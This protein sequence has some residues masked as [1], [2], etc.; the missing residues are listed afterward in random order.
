MRVDYREGRKDLARYHLAY[1]AGLKSC[2]TFSL[3]E[4]IEVS[5]QDEISCYSYMFHAVSDAKG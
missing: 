2:V 3:I 1:L 4:V 5:T